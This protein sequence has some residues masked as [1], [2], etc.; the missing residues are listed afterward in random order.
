M[1]KLSD[2]KLEIIGELT[3]APDYSRSLSKKLNIPKSTISDKLN[4]L[5]NQNILDFKIEGRNKEYFIKNTLESENFIKINEI[6][7]LHKLIEIYPNLKQI[8]QRI[9]EESN[10]EPVI[11]YGSYAKFQ[12]KKDS[13]IDIFI[14]TKK[15]S[16]KQQIEAINT[17]IS[18][19][20]GK[21]NKKNLLAKEIINNH[22]V[23]QNLSEFYNIIKK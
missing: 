11:L 6:Y 13:D 15:I 2:I 17:K 22:I 18:V 5:Y 23:I 1:D 3:K 20:I 10:N 14:I 4:E 19:K 8:I 9:K 21:F 16:L 12:A 7:K